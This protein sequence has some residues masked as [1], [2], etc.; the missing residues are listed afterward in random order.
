MFGSVIQFPDRR[1]EREKVGR[2]AGLQQYAAIIPLL[3]LI[4]C[5]LRLAQW[6][7]N[8]IDLAGLFEAKASRTV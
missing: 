4:L 2:N 6:F 8:P 3:I 1:Q 5:L 7:P